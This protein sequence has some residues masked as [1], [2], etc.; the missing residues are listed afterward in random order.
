MD[1][2]VVQVTKETSS[3]LGDK[4][5]QRR[6]ER[7]LSRETQDTNRGPSNHGDEETGGVCVC[8]GGEYVCLCV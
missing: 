1:V 5:Q 8:V 4:D 6:E 7:W 2:Q 3:N